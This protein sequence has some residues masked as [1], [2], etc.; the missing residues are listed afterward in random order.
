MFLSLPIGG[1]MIFFYVQ[2][3]TDRVVGV[4]LELLQDDFRSLT[5]KS[6]DSMSWTWLMG[7]SCF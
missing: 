5:R 4:T 6:S 7:R 3:S 1:K 2:D